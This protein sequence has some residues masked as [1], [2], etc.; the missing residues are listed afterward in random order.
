MGR[1]DNLAHYLHT[2]KQLKFNQLK[3]PTA[4]A[5]DTAPRSQRLGSLNRRG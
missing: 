4:K 3:P 5:Q 1:H 2:P